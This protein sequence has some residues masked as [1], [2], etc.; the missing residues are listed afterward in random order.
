MGNLS[1]TR[2]CALPLA[3]AWVRVRVRHAY[4]LWCL[5]VCEATVGFSLYMHPTTTCTCDAIDIAAARLF[6]RPPGHPCTCPCTWVP[7]RTIGHRCLMRDELLQCPYIMQWP[8]PHQQNCW[9]VSRELAIAQLQAT[10]LAT[11]VLLTRLTATH[12]CF[13]YS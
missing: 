1:R 13:A 4:G 11:S 12:R 9:S 6:V 2:S 10:C 3:P 5:G 8:S 7:A